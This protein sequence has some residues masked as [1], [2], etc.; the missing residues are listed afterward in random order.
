MILSEAQAPQTLMIT[1]EP[2][3]LHL[4]VSCST[5]RL[6]QRRRFVMV[7]HGQIAEVGVVMSLFPLVDYPGL[8]G[9]LVDIIVSPGP[10]GEPLGYVAE[11]E[12][13]TAVNSCS[14]R[15]AACVMIKRRT[16]SPFSKRSTSAPRVSIMFSPCFSMKFSSSSGV[17][18]CWIS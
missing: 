16:F 12:W 6:L 5:L 4:A 11:G 18:T 3:S 14:V 2:T 17:F 9:T 8:S 15:A 13:N 1:T 7:G 10:R